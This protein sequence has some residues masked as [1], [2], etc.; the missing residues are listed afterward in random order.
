MTK[1]SFIGH[2]VVMQN[3]YVVC[4]ANKIETALLIVPR[5]M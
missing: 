4:G 1:K 5:N 2:K 3:I